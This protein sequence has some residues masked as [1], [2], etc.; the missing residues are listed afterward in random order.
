MRH[1]GQWSMPHDEKPDGENQMEKPDGET[2]RPERKLKKEGRGTWKI[3]EEV[4]VETALTWVK[5][6]EMEPD[7]EQLTIS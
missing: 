3:L 7:M 4:K 2:R 1:P 5:T 6:Q